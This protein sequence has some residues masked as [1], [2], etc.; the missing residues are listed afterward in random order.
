MKSNLLHDVLQDGDYAAFRDELAA[1][2]EAEVRHA[3][4][5]RRGVWLAN[6]ASITLVAAILFFPRAGSKQIVHETVTETVP[7]IHT[8]K[9]APE[10]ILVTT[11]T[12]FAIVE[13]HPSEMLPLTTQPATEIQFITDTELL[14]LF[15]DHP[16][17]LFANNGS[18]RFIFIDPE[19]ARKFMLFN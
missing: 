6:A 17:A 10:Q 1:R 14:D 18:K 4:W 7:T 15:P 13:T 2:F 12:P 9:L 3:K 19:D 5:R 16:T 11:S 8:A